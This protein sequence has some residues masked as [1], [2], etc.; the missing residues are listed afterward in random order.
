MSAKENCIQPNLWWTSKNKISAKKKYFVINFIHLIHKACQ[1]PSTFTKCCQ[2]SSSQS[3]P[4]SSS[5]IPNIPII[6]SFLP[7]QTI[8]SAIHCIGYTARLKTLHNHFW[9]DAF[10]C[11]YDPQWQNTFDLL[12]HELM[13]THH[14]SQFFPQ[15]ELVV[16]TTL[17]M[18]V[19]VINLLIGSGFIFESCS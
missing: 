14:D 3:E 7:Q 8:N 17:N 11:Q 1:I 13:W 5:L 19:S 2:S 15:M 6:F 4:S 18:C 9:W 10:P 16:L 12:V